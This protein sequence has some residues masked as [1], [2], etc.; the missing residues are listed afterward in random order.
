MKDRLLKLNVAIVPQTTDE[1]A[2]HR[3][4]DTK[5]VREL[6]ELTGIKAE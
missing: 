4:E 2:R 6:V 1:M 5:R 3:E